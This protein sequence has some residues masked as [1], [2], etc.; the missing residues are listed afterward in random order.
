LN[1][2]DRPP[3]LERPQLALARR[4]DDGEDEA[5]LVEV[6]AAREQSAPAKHLG[7]DAAHRPHVDRRRVVGVETE[8]FGR[9]VPTRGHVHCEQPLV[10]VGRRGGAGLGGRGGRARRRQ[11]PR[12]PKVADPQLAV[13]V[14]EDVVRLEV[15]VDDARDV[16]VVEAEQELEEEVLDMV[17]G[18]RLA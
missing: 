7:Q 3:V 15:A 4:A 13:L 18:E 16:A 17:V 6:V 1:I 14:E 12:Q 9:A 5:D 2:L 8:Q 11:M 10:V